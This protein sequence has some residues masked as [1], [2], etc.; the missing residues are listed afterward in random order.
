MRASEP[1]RSREQGSENSRRN[2][3]MVGSICSA[4]VAAAARRVAMLVSA[5]RTDRAVRGAL[6]GQRG[7]RAGQLEGPHRRVPALSRPG[8]GRVQGVG[9]PLGLGELGGGPAGAHA[10]RL[11]LLHGRACLDHR[12]PGGLHRARQAVQRPARRRRGPGSGWRGTGGSTPGP[13]R[14][15]RW[16][17]GRRPVTR[18]PARCRPAGTPGWPSGTPRWPRPRSRRCRPTTGRSGPPVPSSVAAATAAAAARCSSSRARNACV[19]ALR[20]S[21]AAASGDSLRRSDLLR[22]TSLPSPRLLRRTVPGPSRGAPVRR[23]GSRS[24]RRGRRP[25]PGVR[26]QALGP[27]RAGRRLADL[28]VRVP[29]R[30][31]TG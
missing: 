21:S 10:R 8:S 25:A 15:A 28:G 30:T 26:A 29:S 4:L 16:R 31:S 22:N 11:G 2:A 13:S 27:G 6:G 20:A 24:S 5:E 3:D 12:G 23:R 7:R 17:A 19:T 14:S 1:V 9:G 18:P